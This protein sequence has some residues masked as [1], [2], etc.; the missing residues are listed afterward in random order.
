MKTAWMM[1][2]VL[3]LMTGAASAAD[4]AALAEEGKGV[5]Q[6]FG[7]AL[8]A[9][10]LAAVEAK[11]PAHAVAVCNVKA[12][13]IAAKV[14]AEKGWSVARSSHRLRNPKNAPDAY[15]DAAIKAFLEREAAGEKAADMA[16][17]GIVE[18][19]G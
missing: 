7:G 14:G 8:K 12:P 4:K 19:E 3:A 2:G 6:A 17:A 1:A 10:L 18:E 5:I 13:E 16:M 15:T 9:E 11:G